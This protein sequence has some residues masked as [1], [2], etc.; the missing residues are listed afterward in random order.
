MCN[1]PDFRK[2]VARRA[3]PQ[4]WRGSFDMKFIVLR[5][6]MRYSDGE[7]PCEGC[8]RERVIRIDERVVDSHEKLLYEDW[9]ARG[10]NHRV[11]SGRIRRDI[12]EEDWVLE[13]NTIDELLEF[14]RV[15]GEKIIVSNNGENNPSIEIYDDY[16][17]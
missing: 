5:T 16:R 2:S 11:V 6:S 13:I 14:S 7:K 15:H 12:I 3:I 10:E 17:E 4:N 1:T 9:F 8:T